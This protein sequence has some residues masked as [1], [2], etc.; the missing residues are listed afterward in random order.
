LKGNKRAEEVSQL[1]SFID[2]LRNNDETCD[3]LK[4]ILKI[5]ADGQS[6]NPDPNEDPEKVDFM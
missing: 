4:F 1:A 6:K 3:D 5:D 2:S